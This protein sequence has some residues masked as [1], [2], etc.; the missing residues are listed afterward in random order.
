LGAKSRMAKIIKLIA[1][2]VGMAIRIL[3]MMKWIN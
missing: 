3:R 1:R 2:R